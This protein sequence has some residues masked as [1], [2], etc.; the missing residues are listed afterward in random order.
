MD[1]GDLNK[2]MN[3]K[4]IIL[5]VPI[6]ILIVFLLMYVSIPPYS[7]H[8]ADFGD[9]SVLLPDDAIYDERGHDVSITGPP[10]EY[11]A[12]IY[13]TNDYADLY[14]EVADELYK[15]GYSP[16]VDNYNDTHY[17]VRM[18]LDVTVLSDVDAQYYLY[19]FFIPKKSYY[20]NNC[21]LKNEN[22]TIWIIKAYDPDF[23]YH[24]FDSIQFGGKNGS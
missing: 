23:G 6:I 8:D 9:F 5:I 17:N 20:D 15:E 11:V 3:K 14:Y 13:K 19:S 22:D 2:F 4:Y 10:N 1:L 24:L 21:T 16:Y 18:Q 7:E 12:K